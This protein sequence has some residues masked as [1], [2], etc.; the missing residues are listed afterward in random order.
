M[1]VV[2]RGG[3][4]H[5]FNTTIA[6]AS[7]VK[8]TISNSAGTVYLWVRVADYTGYL[9]FNAID[10]AAGTNGI[11]LNPLVN[12]GIFQCPTDVKDI[13]LQGALDPTVFEVVV[14]KARG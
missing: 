9:Y 4:P 11:E 12:G 7:L 3:V 10:A 5:V 2:Y 1:L 13:W 8:H 14:F 6:S